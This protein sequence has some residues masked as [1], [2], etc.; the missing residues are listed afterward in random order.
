MKSA[1]TSQ[2]RLIPWASV[3]FTLAITGLA[4]AQYARDPGTYQPNQT[5][6][7]P[8]QPHRTELADPTQY[9]QGST[10]YVPVGGATSAAGGGATNSAGTGYSPE[11]P[12]FSNSPTFS[13]ANSPDL[14]AAL[15]AEDPF[16]R[17]S[18][19][20]FPAGRAPNGANPSQGSYLPVNPRTQTRSNEAN[21]QES[22]RNYRN[23]SLN[24]TFQTNGANSTSDQQNEYLYQASQRQPPVGND[25]F[26]EAS[27]KLPGTNAGTL[28]ASRPT[29]ATP[30]SLMLLLASISANVYLGWIAYDTYNR[31]QD[32]VGDIKM[33]R[34]RRERSPRHA[35]RDYSADDAEVLIS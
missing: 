3:F 27:N 29:T 25:A 18:L 35:D 9:G 13:P 21:S 5:R 1:R 23:D 20:G 14:P 12:R 28:P 2:N 6:T 22:G 19:D 33:S 34:T 7:T 10:H 16:Q 11:D 15:E 32:L 4:L 26:L 24:S 30:L 8:V 31:Y 17:Q